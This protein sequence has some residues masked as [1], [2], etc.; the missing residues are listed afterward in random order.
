MYINI[1][2]LILIFRP[3]SQHPPA[4]V[5]TASMSRNNLPE[6]GADGFP[7]VCTSVTLKLMSLNRFC[8]WKHRKVNTCKNWEYMQFKHVPWWWLCFI[9]TSLFLKVYTCLNFLWLLKGPHFKVTI[10]AW[11]WK[12]VHGSFLRN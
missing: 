2:V 1:I 3:F 7:R 12:S 9:F 5:L 6:G 4:C 10:G 11:P 8:L